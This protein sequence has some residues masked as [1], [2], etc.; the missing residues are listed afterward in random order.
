MLQ[1]LVKC[2][3]VGC[4]NTFV[5]HNVLRKYCC[6]KCQVLAKNE[7]VLHGTVISTAAGLNQLGSGMVLVRFGITHP[8]SG[9]VRWYP[10]LKSGLPR[11]GFALPMIN[12]PYDHLPGSGLYNLAFYGA[13][14]TLASRA[15]R[16]LRNELSS[17]SRVGSVFLRRALET[18]GSALLDRSS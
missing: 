16:S 7:L 2:P 6:R 13:D 12:L 10:S 8:T 5:R 18:P 11:P 1:L 4:A 9:V 3:R 17:G 14:G 15:D